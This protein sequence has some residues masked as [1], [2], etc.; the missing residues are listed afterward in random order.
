MKA[1]ISEIA[2]QI[3]SNEE[4]SEQLMNFLVSKKFRPGTPHESPTIKVEINEGK[5]VEVQPSFVEMPVAVS[6]Y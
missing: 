3:L 4:T 6:K 1:P 2:L 5:V